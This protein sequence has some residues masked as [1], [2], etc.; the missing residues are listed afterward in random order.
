MYFPAGNAVCGAGSPQGGG[1]GMG[2]YLLANASR[3]ARNEMRVADMREQPRCPLLWAQVLMVSRMVLCSC[4]QRQ[5]AFPTVG[6]VTAL[7]MSLTLP[8][9]VRPC[10]EHGASCIPGPSL[11]PTAWHGEGD[12]PV[13]GKGIVR[14]PE[15]SRSQAPCQWAVKVGDAG[16]L[17]RVGTSWKKL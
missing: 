8:G 1:L 17:L 16:R 15:L 10:S 6:P 11:G 13:M 12:L 3:R 7:P 2:G 5:V 9:F 4:S 14:T